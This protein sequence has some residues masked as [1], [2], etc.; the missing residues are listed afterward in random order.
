MPF[1]SEAQRAFMFAKHP[2]VANRW[3]KENPNQGPLPQHVN[4]GP[5]NPAL[6]PPKSIWMQL[7]QKQ[8]AGY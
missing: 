7:A 6:Q 2:E 8:K 5:L 4:Q 1:K 3:A